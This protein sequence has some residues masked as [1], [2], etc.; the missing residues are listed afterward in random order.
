MTL[1]RNITIGC[2]ILGVLCVGL[3][4]SLKIRSHSIHLRILRQQITD[5]TLLVMHKKGKT[6]ESPKIESTEPVV[7]SAQIS[8]ESQEG[9]VHESVDG[10]DAG[11]SDEEEEEGEVDGIDDSVVVVPSP[12]AST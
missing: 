9:P 1:K 2:V 8:E 7:S 3:A 12:L 6:N 10:S 4:I 5:L 11:E